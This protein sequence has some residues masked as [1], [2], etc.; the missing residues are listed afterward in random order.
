MACNGD[1]CEV[2][3]FLTLRVCLQV[4][5]LPTEFVAMGFMERATARGR[6]L[7]AQ[8]A[9][10]AGEVDAEWMANPECAAARTKVMAG[11]ET[12][13]SKAKE[14]RAPGAE[15]LVEVGSSDTG[16]R[17]GAKARSTAGVLAQLP[18]LSAVNDAALSRHGVQQLHQ[19][20]VDDPGDPLRALWLAEALD[21]V[22]VDLGRYRRI[23][24]FTSPTYVVRRQAILGAMALGAEAQDST[25]LRLLK[26]AFVGARSQV[27]RDPG[28]DAALHVLARVYLAQHQPKTAL[29]VTKRALTRAPEDGLLWITLARCYMQLG[30][31]SAS[32]TIAAQRGANY[33]ATYA[34]E[35]LAQLALLGDA[36]TDVDVAVSSFERE[37]SLITPEGRQAYL[38]VSVDG[39]G[40]LT[41]L[42]AE[43]TRRAS[44]ALEWLKGL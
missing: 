3:A 14:A 44:E 23:R 31:S 25:R 35:L 2:R 22:Q 33:G 8:A 5:A 19:E 36:Q 26:A 13:I 9:R 10:V 6:L 42:R 20:L 30:S 1:V 16:Q 28:S 21:R 4:E 41:Q 12:G 24:S 43:Q 11:R 18:V 38:G 7:A 40:A 27:A 34:H 15:L 29:P 37:R 17:L 32:A 39:R